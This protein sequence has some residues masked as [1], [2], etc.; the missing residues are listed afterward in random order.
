[1]QRDHSVVGMFTHHFGPARPGARLFRASC[2]LSLLAAGC[3]D[4]NSNGEALHAYGHAEKALTAEQCSYWSEDDRVTYCHAANLKKGKFVL[5]RTNVA[6]CVNGHAGHDGDFI[7]LDGTCDNDQC[8]PVGAPWDPT[9]EC[10]DNMEVV[11]GSCACAAGY[12]AQSD[13]TCADVDECAAGADNCADDATCTNTMGD[14][15]C[16]CN[17]GYQG[18]GTVCADI[19][20]CSVH[21]DDCADDAAC[22]NTAGAFSCACNVGYQGDGV[23]CTDIDECSN[24][25]G[26][27]SAHASCINTPGGRTCACD[28]GYEGD[29]LTCVANTVVD[30]E[31]PLWPV[32]NGNDSYTINAD[33]TVTDDVTGLVWSQTTHDVS[34][35]NPYPTALV[36]AQSHCSAKGSGWRVPTVVELMTLI[37]LSRTGMLNPAFSQAGQWVQAISATAFPLNT[38]YGY[39][40]WFWGGSSQLVSYWDFAGWYVRCLKNGPPLLVGAPPGAPA[41][42]YSASNGVVTDLKTGLEWEQT[43]AVAG[44][45]WS[46]ANA[47]C[48]NLGTAGGGWRLPTLREL[49][50]VFDHRFPAMYQFMDPI[51]QNASGYFTWSS[52]LVAAT[53]RHAHM[54]WSQYTPGQALGS[55]H[56]GHAGDVRCVR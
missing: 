40:V 51:F 16:A 32:P 25:N 23:S 17:A 38:G 52:S 41:D 11:G 19:D 48:Q 28:A 12:A 21:T 14:F 53:G 10:C 39:G 31:W 22:T 33:G 42:Q 45:T 36:A 27:C 7:S 26:G 20:E 54:S 56:D 4:G 13:G 9:I 35:S 15:S 8:F 47:Y 34:A 46:Q 37:D 24:G 3:V 50:S 6:G 29:G 55:L 43:P 44:Y 1:M 49:Q 30:P 2:I 18:D 5:I